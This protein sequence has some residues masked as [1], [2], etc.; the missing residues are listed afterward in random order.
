MEIRVSDVIRVIAQRNHSA[1]LSGM[2]EVSQKR[3]A[4]L[5]GVSEPTLSTMKSEQLER[6]AALAAACG[7]KLVPITE[8]TFDED[9]IRALE[10]LVAI[11]LRRSRTS[12]F[13]LPRCPT[14]A[15]RTPNH[16]GRRGTRPSRVSN[17]TR[18]MLAPCG[19]R[20]SSARH[21]R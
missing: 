17:S 1:L 18:P 16:L 13:R 11:S 7:L 4:D 2:A 8:H 5:I 12:T 20:W 19:S 14:F 6:F 9:H 15:S 21:D 3:V 10:T